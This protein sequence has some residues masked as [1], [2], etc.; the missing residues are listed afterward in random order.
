VATPGLR[1]AP[2][3]A[4]PAKPRG[5]DGEHRLDRPPASTAVSEPSIG[6]AATRRWGRSLSK[7]STG[8]SLPAIGH[9]PRAR[10]VVPMTPTPSDMTRR[11][12]LVSPDPGVPAP[13]LPHGGHRDHAPRLRVGGGHGL[14]EGRPPR[15]ATTVALATAGRAVLFAGGTGPS[16]WHGGADAAPSRLACVVD[17]SSPRLRNPA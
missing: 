9:I 7:H 16:I 12:T 14:A 2:A 5:N 3:S 6:N 4:S 13:R 15:E 17:I 1:S 8:Q 11:P 10:G